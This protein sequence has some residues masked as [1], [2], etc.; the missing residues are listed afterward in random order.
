MEHPS[1]NHEP[2]ED[3]LKRITV[4]ILGRVAKSYMQ[5]LNREDLNNAAGQ[6]IEIINQVQAEQAGL[7]ELLKDSTSSDDQ[8]MRPYWLQY[9]SNQRKLNKLLRNRN[10]LLGYLEL[11]VYH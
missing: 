10:K 11:V 6:L 8:R 4:P 5:T 3:P 1:Q 2:I 9:E 7:E